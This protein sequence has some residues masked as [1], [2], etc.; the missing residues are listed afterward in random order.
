M[1][2]LEGPD[3]GHSMIYYDEKLV[4]K[5]WKKKKKKKAQC[6][7]KFEPLTS[8]SRGECSTTALGYIR[9]PYFTKSYCQCLDKNDHLVGLSLISAPLMTEDLVIC[10]ALDDGNRLFS[11]R[12]MSSTSSCQLESRLPTRRV[13]RRR[14]LPCA[15]YNVERKLIR[16]QRDYYRGMP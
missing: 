12:P 11:M 2:L 4:K 13:T 8:R 16:G 15:T 10:S 7:A 14:S 1:H 3:L 6:P 5:R 9:G